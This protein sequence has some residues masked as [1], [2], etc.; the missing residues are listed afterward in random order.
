MV[1]DVWL[2][3]VTTTFQNLGRTF[4]AKGWTYK[5]GNEVFRDRINRRIDDDAKR[6]YESQFHITVSCICMLP[7]CIESRYFSNGAFGA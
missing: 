7:R 2:R 6:R 5:V 3:A 1:S 4:R